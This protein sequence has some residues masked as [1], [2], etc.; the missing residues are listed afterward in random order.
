MIQSIK[1]EEPN[2]FNDL[3][4]EHLSDLTEELKTCTNAKI[5]KILR[6][7]V[8]NVTSMINGSMINGLSKH[9]LFASSYEELTRKSDSS[10]DEHGPPKRT[11]KKTVKIEE[12]P[13]EPAIVAKVPRA[14]RSLRGDSVRDALLRAK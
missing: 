14:K 5:N 8:S 2:K 6:G 10:D 12:V 3:L 7:E 13:K 4:A 9:K 11:S 1:P